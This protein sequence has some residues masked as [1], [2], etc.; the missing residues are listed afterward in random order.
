MRT[1]PAVKNFETRCK[2]LSPA[3]FLFAVTGNS[4]FALSICFASTK[5]KYLVANAPWLS[6]SANTVT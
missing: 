4:T 2:G 3:L 1:F 6:G 5:W